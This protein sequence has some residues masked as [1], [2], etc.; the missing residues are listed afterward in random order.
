MINFDYTDDDEVLPYNH[1]DPPEI[2]DIESEVVETEEP[3][4]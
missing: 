4:F 3:P 2:N 1:Y